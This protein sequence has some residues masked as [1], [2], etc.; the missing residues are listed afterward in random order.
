M[1]TQQPSDHG[2]ESAFPRFFTGAG[3]PVFLVT[4]TVLYELFL[5]AV[6]FAPEGSGPWS[7]FALEFKVWCFSYDTR[8]GGMEWSAV[9]IMLLEPVF[10]TG[11]VLLLWRKAVSTLLTPAGWRMHRVP[12]AAGVGVAALTLGILYAYGLSETE[13]VDA[14]P[15]PG[16]RIR[17][18]L[19]PPHFA[20]QDQQGAPVTLDDFQGQAVL[21]TGVYGHCTASCPMILIELR[22]LLDELPEDVREDLQI[23]AISLDPEGDTEEVMQAVSNAYNFTYPQFRFLNG[24][25]EIMRELIKRY[26]FSAFF[27]ERTGMIDHANLFILVDAQ[28][29]IA[30]RFNLDPRHA[31]WVR[32]AVISL[33]REARSR[34]GDATAQVRR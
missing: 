13:T 19:T 23:L 1:S 25:P 11:I 21:I 34:R 10:I 20:L 31:P 6:L 27:N 22:T 4:I 17:T 7:R 28:G 33:V 26:H 5:L 30:Y 18:S 32:E 15:F 2:G 8:T 16:E 9:W 12:M 14:L 24:E 29:K 3:L